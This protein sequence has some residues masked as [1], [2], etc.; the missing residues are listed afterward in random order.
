LPNK[1]M[2]DLLEDLRIGYECS[3]GA[4]RPA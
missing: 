4:P 1:A 2:E 3:F